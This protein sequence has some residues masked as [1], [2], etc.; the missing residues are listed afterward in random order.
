MDACLA[1]PCHTKATCSD[2]SAPALDA[3]CTCYPGYIG[4]GLAN[5]SGCSGVWL[6]RK[7]SW[8]VDSAG[9]PWVDN[10]VTHDATK[11]LDGDQETFWNPIGAEKSNNDWYIVLDL[12]VP[13]TLTRIAVN[14][15]GDTTHDIAAFKLLKSQDGLTWE[16][17]VSVT[18][19]E[20]GTGR[21]QEFGG[22]EGTARYWRFVVTQTH[23]GWQPYLT[24]LYLY[25]LLS[26]ANV[27]L[28]KTA[29]QT[30]YHSGTSGSVAVDGNTATDYFS[31]SCTHTEGEANPAWWVDLEQSYA[32]DRV[33]I[34]NRQDCCAERLNP[35]NIHIGDSPQLTTNPRCGGDIQIDVSQPAISVSCE[36]MKGRYVGVRLPGASRVLTLCEV[37]IVPDYPM[38]LKNLGCWEDQYD[39]AIS[40][41][42]GTD[43]RLD[44]HSYLLRTDPIKKCYQVAKDR[45]YK[46]FAVQDSGQ[47][48]SSATAADTYR[49][50]GPSTGCAEGEGGSWSND[51]Y[52]IIDA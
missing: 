16:H 19:V 47:C 18:D 49:K 10:G 20:T 39:R 28:G 45:G 12:T 21:R 4:D 31:G 46:V 52:E 9:P 6:K 25:G 15:L 7:S 8:V 44:G 13:K 23:S 30:S 36:D 34:F 48:F 2:N 11:A 26:G 32:V 41:M 40:M 5:G 51:V 24:E 17:V 29:F 14:N 35:F 1:K 27:A 38:M 42:E 33:V 37:Q 43:P 3:T 22:F 50:Y